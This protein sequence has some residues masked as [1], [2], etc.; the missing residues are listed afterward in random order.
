MRVDAVGNIVFTCRDP[1]VRWSDAQVALMSAPGVRVRVI[2][3]YRE[4][5]WMPLLGRLRRETHD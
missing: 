3:D 2:V 4:L 1:C 5:P